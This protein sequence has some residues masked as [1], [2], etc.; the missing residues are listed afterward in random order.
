MRK[1]REKKLKRDEDGR[2]GIQE[3]LE[4]QLDG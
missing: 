1:G 4:T 3:P 2:G